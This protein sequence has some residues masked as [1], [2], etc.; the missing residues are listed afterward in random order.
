ML[1]SSRKSVFFSLLIFGMVAFTTAVFFF[2]ITLGWI[3]KSD[4]WTA[5]IFSV[6][7]AWLLWVYFGTNYKL[8]DTELI[9]RS[10]PIRGKI[11]IRQI[12]EI[13]K[14]KTMYS[15]LKPATAAKGLIIKFRKYD[16][17]YI[18]PVSNDLFIA[19]ILKYN[20]NIIISE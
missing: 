10:G 11:E 5:I 2:G 4:Y 12:R 19:E 20:P 6:I 14:G 13:V 9:Y 3:G 16:E 7:N 8:T 18:S 1:F 17:I 15:G